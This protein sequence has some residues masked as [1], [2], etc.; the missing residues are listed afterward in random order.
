MFYPIFNFQ[1]M[2]WLTRVEETSSSSSSPLKYYPKRI[3]IRMYI[4]E[5]MFLKSGFVIVCFVLFCLIGQSD[6]TNEQIKIK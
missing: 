1:L 2:T 4:S 5:V 6:V 3:F